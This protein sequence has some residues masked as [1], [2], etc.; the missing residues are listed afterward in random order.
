MEVCEMKR[1]VIVEDR[2]WVT[3]R[4][5]LEIKKQEIEVAAMIYYPNSNSTKQEQEKL[6][7]EFENKTGVD[8][9]WV[10]SQSEFVDAMDR[11]YAD[12]RVVFLVDFDL[13]G[14]G[15]TNFDNRINVLYVKAKEKQEK[16]KERFWFYTTGNV[17][18]KSILMAQYKG[19]VIDVNFNPIRM[20]LEWDMG[21]IQEMVRG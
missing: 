3:Q 5:V 6:V 20:S 11:W 2:P 21:Q 18:V 19:H 14:D 13:K 12:E 10:N 9:Q 17:D 16:G 15:S 8:V 7:Q 4:E 1:I